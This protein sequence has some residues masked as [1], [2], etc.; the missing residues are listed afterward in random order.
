MAR[1]QLTTRSRVLESIGS[2]GGGRALEARLSR[3][4]LLL[5]GA[6]ASIT[7]LLAACGGTD[8]APTAT[9]AAAS[10]ATPAPATA[11]PTQPPAHT[12]TSVS[13]PSATPASTPAQG[14]TPT[15]GEWSFTDDRGVTVTLPEPPARIVAQTT[16]GAALWDLG[17]KPVAVFG[18]Y[19]TADGKPDFQAGNLD[20]DQVEWL[21]DYGELDQE[22]LAALNADI[23]VDFTWGAGLLWYLDEELEAQVKR[24]VPTIGISFENR[25]IIESIGRLEDLA[26]SVGA[27]LNA[28]QLVEDRATFAAAEQELVSAIERLALLLRSRPR[29]R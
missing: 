19:R 5:G 7:G 27:D 29:H 2:R 24:I 11:T 14:T 20:L 10:P 16:V 6:A 22:K 12:P 13:A 9:P 1:H 18:P 25:S 3:R 4:T 26:V 23:Y 21:G 17:V 8:A 28:P 15:S